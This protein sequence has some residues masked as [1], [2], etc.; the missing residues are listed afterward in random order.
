MKAK[1]L[2]T[3]A[4]MAYYCGL[5]EFFYWLNRNAKRILTFHNVLPDRLFRGGVANGVSGCESDFLA[6][7]GECARRF[8]FSLDLAD[9][10]SLT[11]TFDDG[12][13]NQY[14][15]AFARL[16]ELGIPAYLFVAGDLLGRGA[17]L[18]IDKLTHWVD[19]VPAG[20]YMLDFDGG[21][22]GDIH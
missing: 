5:I 22:G 9:P 17:G 13:R 3:I 10:K 1:I 2:H 8:P 19:N 16:R 18:T 20:S 14:S 6:I 21:G 7:V 11:L 12:Y 15:V 4:K